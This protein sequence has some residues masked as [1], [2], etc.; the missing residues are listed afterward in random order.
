ML[1]HAQLLVPQ[2]YSIITLWFAGI[3]CLHFRKLL[4]NYTIIGQGKAVSFC[5]RS[6]LKSVQAL[7]IPLLFCAFVAQSLGAA[8]MYNPVDAQ[9]TVVMGKILIAVSIT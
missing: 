9:Q 5:N 1:N 3:L 8:R 6:I 7:F 2:M 4:K